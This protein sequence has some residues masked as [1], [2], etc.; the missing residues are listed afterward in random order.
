MK[1]TTVPK[2]L[3]DGGMT[4]FDSMRAT[5]IDNP[6]EVLGLKKDNK[7]TRKQKYQLKMK[8]R[9]AENMMCEKT[10]VE[11]APQTFVI[12]HGWGE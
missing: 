8:R 7:P 2:I 1:T 11:I 12:N 3:L 9:E 6:L 5:G 10:I 4:L